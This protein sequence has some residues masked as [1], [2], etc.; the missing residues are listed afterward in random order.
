MKIHSFTAK[1]VNDFMN[2]DIKFNPKLTFL[3][4]IN[5]SGKTS[6]VNLITAT[7]QLSFQYLANHAFSELEIAL[8]FPKKRGLHRIKVFK[9]QGRVTITSTGT[10]SRLAFRVPSETDFSAPDYR[11]SEAEDEYYRSLVIELSK[12]PVYE[13]I[14][15]L[16]KPIFLGIER[17]IYD[18]TNFDPSFQRTAS[19]RLRSRRFRNRFSGVLGVSLEQAVSIAEEQYASYKSNLQNIENALKNNI[20]QNA[21]VYVDRKRRYFTL[22]EEKE[23]QRQK[24]II[25][26][27][28]R[29]IGLS[30]G[31][32]EPGLNSFFNKLSSINKDLGHGKVEGKLFEQ[33]KLT[34]KESGAVVQWLINYPQYDRLKR[35]VEF[36]QTYVEESRKL[37]LPI[38]GYLNNVN[39]FLRDSNKKLLFGKDNRL[40][41]IL[42]KD[43]EI[44]ISSLSSG[45]R[46]ILVMITHLSFLP[47][48]EENIFM[49]DEPELSLHVRW[50]ELF[51]DSIREANPDIQI[52]L[53]TH[54]P[55]IILDRR[56]NCVDLAKSM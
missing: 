37:S 49:V 39:Q 46:Q 16:P 14:K 1:S 3:T 44:P 42:G 24:T 20:L 17:R 19:S 52:I 53:A 31:E 25:N 47:E 43:K 27:T 50:Q 26:E 23:L 36:A 4:G 2:F 40:K 12:N 15:N 13:T 21:L 48:K 35:I 29:A 41:L 10:K 5:G 11:L 51:V 7:L 38:E 56:K 34:N 55:S 32:I 22:V 8:K 9:K 45:E 28:Y 33:K 30:T 54:S 6:V 18:E